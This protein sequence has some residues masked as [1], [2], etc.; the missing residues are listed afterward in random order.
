[1][2]TPTDLFVRPHIR[3]G[4]TVEMLP[5]SARLTY[6]RQGCEIDFPSDG[7]AE[8]S[9]L[10]DLLQRGTTTEELVAAAPGFAEQL[11]VLIFE[12]DRLGLLDEADPGVP[13]GAL[14]G[15]Q[16]YRELIR[17]ARRMEGR[18]AQSELYTAL[19]SGTA[20]RSVL[21]GYAIEYYHL[22]RMSVGLIAPVLAHAASRRTQELLQEFV[23]SEMGHDRMLADALATVGNRQRLAG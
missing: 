5:A 18:V 2:A 19:E 4:V 3:D 13:D 8:A 6:R 23:G 20:G 15:R 1:M 11:D 22:V 12:L 9:L 16:F 10:F 17:F 21:I 7:V 14:S